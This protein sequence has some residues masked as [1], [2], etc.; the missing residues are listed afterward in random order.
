MATRRDI[1]VT[2]IAIVAVLD[3][4]CEFKLLKRKEFRTDQPGTIAGH[5]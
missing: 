4:E 2:D 3:T 1:A 5:D